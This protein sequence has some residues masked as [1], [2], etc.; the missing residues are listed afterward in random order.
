VRTC[1]LVFINDISSP[2][3]SESTIPAV[4]STLLALV[5]ANASQNP[6]RF[7]SLMGVAVAV[8]VRLKHVPTPPSERLSKELQ[9][10]GQMHF[11]SLNH[12]L[13]L[14]ISG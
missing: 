13:I 10:R 8:L 14:Y 7:L 11:F 3:K 6:V 9:V 2:L 12:F 1:L 5:R 4:I